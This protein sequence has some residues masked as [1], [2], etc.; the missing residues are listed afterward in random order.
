VEWVG[1]PVAFVVATS[2]VAADAGAKLVKVSYSP[3]TGQSPIITIDQA[4]AADAF[5]SDLPLLSA[6]AVRSS[7]RH[8]QHSL[9]NGSAGNGQPVEQ[10]DNAPQRGL[11]AEKQS[12]EAVA[13][14]IAKAPRSIKGGCYSLPAQQHFYM[15]TQVSLV[16]PLEDGA[17]R[18]H[19]STQSLDAVQ[20]AVAQVL[21]LP[22]NKVTV[23][24]DWHCMTVR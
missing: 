23:G 16:D 8:H 10:T 9:G 7:S 4:I 3:V 15:E 11:Q 20:L 2:Q 18:V 17:V 5:Y 21:Q 14:L 12:V 13:G 22:F 1:Q 6:A 19:S 24:K